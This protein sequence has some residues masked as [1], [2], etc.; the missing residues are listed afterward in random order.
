MAA[1]CK[2]SQHKCIHALIQDKQKPGNMAG[3]LMWVLAY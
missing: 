2:E 1:K 3:L